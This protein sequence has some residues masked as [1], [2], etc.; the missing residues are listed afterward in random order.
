[1]KLES[2]FN[3]SA[4]WFEGGAFESFSSDLGALPKL[5]IPDPRFDLLG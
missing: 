3:G 2:D 5:L 4:P 1:L